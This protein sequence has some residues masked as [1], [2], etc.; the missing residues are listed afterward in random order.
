MAKNNPKKSKTNDA[1]R[2]YGIVNVEKRNLDKKELRMIL[3]KSW[4][5]LHAMDLQK[6]VYHEMKL[7]DISQKYAVSIVAVLNKLR[8]N[9]A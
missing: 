9:G 5:E 2:G 3:G 6:M 7:E 8:F 4:S 1:K